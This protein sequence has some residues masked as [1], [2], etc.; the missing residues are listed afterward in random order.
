MIRFIITANFLLCIA[1]QILLQTGAAMFNGSEI[2]R[3]ALLALKDKLTNGVPEA[4]P[5]WNDS[6]HF[7]KWQGVTCNL[8]HMRV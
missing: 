8:R 3:L 2:D 7:C 1:S 4:L 6:V 5:S